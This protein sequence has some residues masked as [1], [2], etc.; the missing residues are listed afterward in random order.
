MATFDPTAYPPA[1]AELV[2]QPRLNPLGPGELNLSIRPRLEALTVERAFP[3]SAVRDRAMAAACLAGLWFH[4]D[5]L[6]EAHRISQELDTTTG[7]YWHGLV[8][9]RE[10]DFSNAKYWFRRVGDHA[11]F[12]ALQ[13]AAAPLAE[14]AP[15]AAAFLARQRAWDP[16]AF[17]DLCEAALAGQAP[18]ESL[19]Q[20]I[21]QVEWQLL[22]T[23]CY[24]QAQA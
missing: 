4:H 18:T 13:A 16:F 6:D 11:I 1:L 9:R 8:H 12:P 10:P 21:Q 5:F 14:G 20:R 19:C 24:Q 15:P 3:P 2:R 17:I 23:Y 22:F 7:S